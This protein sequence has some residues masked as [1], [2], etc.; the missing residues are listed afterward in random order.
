MGYVAIFKRKEDEERENGEQ[1]VE[2]PKSMMSPVRTVM[3]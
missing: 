2:R 3:M 1:I